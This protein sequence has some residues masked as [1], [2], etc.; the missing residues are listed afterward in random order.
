MEISGGEVY[1]WISEKTE[2]DINRYLTA[3]GIEWTNKKSLIIGF[4]ESII[5]RT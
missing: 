5:Y 4:S 2:D 1:P 3:K